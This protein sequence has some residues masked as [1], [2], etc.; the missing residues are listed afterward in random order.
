M[1]FA[2]GAA[3]LIVVSGRLLASDADGQAAL[4]LG[5]DVFTSLAEPRCSVCHT[6]AD[7]GAAGKVGPSLDEQQPTEDDVK[8]SIMEGGGVMPPYAGILTPEQIDAVAKYVSS[9]AGKTQ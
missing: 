6:L 5:K 3:V 9:V 8:L 7:A 4:E 2:L 1:R